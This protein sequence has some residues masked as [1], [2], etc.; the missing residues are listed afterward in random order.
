MG[1]GACGRPQEGGSGSCGQE[2]GQKPDILWT[3]YN[4]WPFKGKVMLLGW[5]MPNAEKRQEW[6]KIAFTADP[7]ILLVYKKLNSDSYFDFDTV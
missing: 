3:S 7:F 4:G 6:P 2:G 1:R 5:A